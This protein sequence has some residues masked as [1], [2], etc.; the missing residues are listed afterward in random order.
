MVEAQ[1]NVGAMYNTG[2]GV[3]EDADRAFEWF[4]KAA[5]QGLAV[6]QFN[7]GFSYHYGRGVKQDDEMAKIWVKKSCDAGFVKGCAVLASFSDDLKIGAR[8][9]SSTHIQTIRHKDSSK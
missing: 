4:E 5:K 3:K 6:A 9:T 8:A 7:V 1:F 2:R